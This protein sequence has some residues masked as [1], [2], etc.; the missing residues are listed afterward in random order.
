M[1]PGELVAVMGPSGS[2]TSSLHAAH[3]RRELLRAKARTLVA[4]L[5]VLLPVTG[6]VALDTLLRTAEVSPQ[7]SL[8]AEPGGAEARIEVFSDASPVRQSPDARGRH[9]R[10]HLGRARPH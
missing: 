6:V 10:V 8:A 5:M 7:E 4:L 3:R 9:R 2:G 1:L